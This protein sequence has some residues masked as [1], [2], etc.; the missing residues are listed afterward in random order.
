M[1]IP[2]LNK[3]NVPIPISGYVFPFIDKTD[4]VLKVRKSNG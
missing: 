3:I 4:H 2:I 1:N